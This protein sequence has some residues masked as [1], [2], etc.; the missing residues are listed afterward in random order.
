MR[1]ILLF[2]SFIFC[3]SNLTLAQD[4]NGSHPSDDQGTETHPEES[5]EAHANACGFVHETEFNPGKTAFHHVSDQNVYSIGPLQLPLPCFLYAPDHGWEIFSSGRFEADAHGVGTKAYNRYVMYDGSVRRVLSS[6]FPMGEVDLGE[7]AVYN[8]E[9]E[10]GDVIKVCFDG[11]QWICDSK[12]TADG[13]V[14]GGGVTSFYDFS[15]TKNVLTLFIVFGLMAWMFITAARAYKKRDGQA[16]KGIQLFLEPMYE[17]IQDEVVK[18][19]LGDKWEQYNSLIMAIFFFI[20]G[21]NLYGQI[22]FFGGSNVTGNLSFTL[23]L[24]LLVFIITNVSGNKHYWG[25]VLWMPGLPPLLKVLI[26]TPVEIMGLFIKPLTLML[27]LFG[28]IIAGHMVI[29]IFVGLIFL[30][31]QNGA[32][33]GTAIGTAIGTTFLTMFMMAIELLVAFI[34]AFVFAILTASYIGAATEEAHH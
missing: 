30:F 31:G 14:F 13:G 3:L 6:D 24:A 33:P 1:K 11:K 4:Q 8:V 29:V 32:N 34:Q 21:L 16:P 2:F 9:E 10:D 28:N 7:H 15:I 27:R 5:H 25:H 19:F 20:L 22:P 26:I 12:S 18:P 23:V 17:F